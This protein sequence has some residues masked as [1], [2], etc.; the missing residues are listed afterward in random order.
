LEAFRKLLNK[1]AE[2]SFI[3]SMG[4]SNVH[5]LMELCIGWGL[6]WLIIFDAKGVTKEYNK[7][8]REFFDN[9]EK[10]AKKKILILTDFDGIEDLFDEDDIGKLIKSNDFNRGQKRDLTIEANGG[11]ELVARLFLEQ[12]NTNKLKRTDFSDATLKNFNQIFD[13]IYEQFSIP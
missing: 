6:D 8:K 13:F 4:V 3:P 5:L 9:D 12:V 10:E 2:F 1:R 7:I 11:K